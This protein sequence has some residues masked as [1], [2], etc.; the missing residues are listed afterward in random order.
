M[1]KKEQIALMRRVTE[2]ETR[3]MELEEH[4]AKHDMEVAALKRQVQN[5][6]VDAEMH[7]ERLGWVRALTDGSG[8]RPHQ[9][10]DRNI[11]HGVRR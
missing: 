2:L 8:Q 5:L 3:N 4:A 7:L 11:G 6:K 9:L 1:T 10:H